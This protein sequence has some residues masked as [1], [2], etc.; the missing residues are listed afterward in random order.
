MSDN[1]RNGAK[2]TA[3][4]ML[5]VI[6]AEAAR[7]KT[8]VYDGN[9]FEYR[10]PSY[11]W[12]SGSSN[13]QWVSVSPENEYHGPGRFYAKDIVEIRIKSSAEAKPIIVEDND[14]YFNDFNSGHETDQKIVSYNGQSCNDVIEAQLY[15]W[16]KMQRDGAK[17]AI[18]TLH[19]NQNRFDVR[20]SRSACLYTFQGPR[21]P[22]PGEQYG[23]GVEG[24][25]DW[26][27][28]PLWN[29]PYTDLLG[30]CGSDPNAVLGGPSCKVLSC[31]NGFTESSDGTTCC[32]PA[33]SV[34]VLSFDVGCE[35]ASCKSGYTVSEAK[36]SCVAC[37][38][39][40]V[41]TYGDECAVAACESGHSISSDGTACAECAAVPHKVSFGTGCEVASC[42]SGY[43][44]SEAKDSCVE[45]SVANAASYGT[46]CVVAACESGYRVS[47][48]GKGCTQCEAA[49][50]LSFGV[51]CEVASCESGYTA[52]E[53]KD[54]CVACSVANAASYGTE[55]AVAACVSGYSVSSD[56]KAC[57]QSCRVGFA[58]DDSRQQCIAD[59]SGCNLLLLKQNADQNPRPA[60]PGTCN[61]IFAA[62]S[63][64]GT[65]RG[66]TEAEWNDCEVDKAMDPTFVQA[67][68]MVDNAPR[69]GTVSRTEYAAYHRVA[70]DQVI[71]LVF[72][73]QE[74]PLTSFR[75]EPLTAVQRAFDHL[76]V[77]NT[78]RACC[79]AAINGGEPFVLRQFEDFV[80]GHASA[81]A[82]P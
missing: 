81:E 9:D 75:R 68:A 60:V 48:D 46:E 21:F 41:A 54:S 73:G 36:D 2:I 69:N 70:V 64:D 57:Q 7:Y 61:A 65:V 76:D 47:E 15:S 40:N 43:T 31:N 19:G 72:E 71:D 18:F 51:G 22:E 35:V 26:T 63:A 25:Y 39:A 37:S 12:Y 10:Y 49:H 79:M 52:S 1:C 24:N 23:P 27:A 38:V 58:Y 6:G 66:L 53:A 28:N 5:S 77:D 67:F 62:C 42:E 29:I 74:L 56:G 17:L 82:S 34:N 11:R 78:G 30:N 80:N 8:Y 20:I 59:I 33:V 13:G 4:L 3:A 16:I 55:C 50:A 44:A 45:C 32:D 14:P